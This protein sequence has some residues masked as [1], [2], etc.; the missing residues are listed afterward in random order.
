MQFG[1]IIGEPPDLFHYVFKLVPLWT[2]DNVVKFEKVKPPPTSRN[3]REYQRAIEDYIRRYRRREAEFC[4][5]FARFLI[6]SNR[7]QINKALDE[8]RNEADLKPILG[9][10]LRIKNYKVH[11]KEVPIG[12]STRADIVVYHRRHETEKERGFLGRVKDRRR[13]R[14]YEFLGV[15]LKTAKRAKDSL[16]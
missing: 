5:E 12:A 11:P 14:W 7:R 13:I 1:D 8:P 4:K 9:R 3:L 16:H 6:D 15:E 2:L 10:A